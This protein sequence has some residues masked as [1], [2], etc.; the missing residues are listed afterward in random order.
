MKDRYRVVTDEFLGYSP[1]VKYWWWPFNYWNIE[2]ICEKR[3]QTTFS[4]LDE[5]KQVCL[6]HESGRLKQIEIDVVGI[7][8]WKN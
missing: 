8:I 6:D 4:T 5:A 1:E 2:K 3:T 7:E